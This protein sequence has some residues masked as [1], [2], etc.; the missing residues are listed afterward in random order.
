MPEGVTYNDPEKKK[1]ETFGL[2]IFD[3]NDGDIV[4]VADFTI[5]IE[6]ISKQ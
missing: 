4:E 5:N 6:K 3:D 1:S 2:G